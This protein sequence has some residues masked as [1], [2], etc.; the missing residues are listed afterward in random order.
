MP[1]PLS[2]LKI[3]K[4]IPY[5]F[6]SLFPFKSTKIA[7][8]WTSSFP[9]AIEIETKVPSLNINGTHLAFAANVVDDGL[10]LRLNHGK[11]DL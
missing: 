10:P 6:G 9:P 4:S 11:F 5:L 8:D 1:L 7:L 3:K 2:L